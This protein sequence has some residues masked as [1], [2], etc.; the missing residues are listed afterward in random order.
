MR[1]IHAHFEQ[2]P[3]LDELDISFLD[4][5]GAPRAVTVLFGGGGVGKTSLLTSIASTRPGN[6]AVQVGRTNPARNVVGV[7]D[8]H[9][10]EDDPS[11]PHT[12]RVVTP[13]ADLVD[14]EGEAVRRREQAYF[15]RKAKSGGFAFALIPSTRWFA[16]HTFVLS[17]PDTALLRHDTRLQFGDDPSRGDLTRDAKQLLSYAEIAC[18]LG[19]G[20]PR[21]Q[22]LRQVRDA[23]RSSVNTLL[24]LTGYQ[25]VGADPVTLEAQFRRGETPPVEFNELPTRARHLVGIITGAFRSLWAAYPEVSPFD[26]EGVIC[27]DEVEIAQDPAIHSLLVPALTQALPN[28]Q[29]IIT[30]SSAAVTDGCSA[31][32]VFALRRP[33][34]EHQVQLYGGAEAR[35]Q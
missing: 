25:F 13:S 15:D 19:Q 26:A 17:A 2:L 31:T 30:T 35:L 21:E 7:C 9:L 6:A 3:T 33:A 5:E 20:T 28:V 23:L 12:L 27:V 32:E 4:P 16:R 14:G 10:G 34:G 24:R 11:R 1:L 22:H 18:A 29:W 8:W